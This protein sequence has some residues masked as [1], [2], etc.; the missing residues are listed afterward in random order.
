M[1]LLILV[2]ATGVL[3]RAVTIPRGLSISTLVIRSTSISTS[4]PLCVLF[5]L[6]NYLSI[7]QFSEAVSQT[8]LKKIRV[9]T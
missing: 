9:G 7:Y 3:R 1:D 6:F 5:G 8:P 2:V 4:Q